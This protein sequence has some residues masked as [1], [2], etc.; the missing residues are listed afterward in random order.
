MSQN[1]LT[2]IL[3]SAIITGIS[4]GPV[5]EFLGI[6]FAQ[7]PTG[8]LCFQLP[9]ALP[10]YNVSF[11]ATAYSPA[12]PQ[13]AIEPPIVSGLLAEMLDYLMNTFYNIVTTPAKDCLT[14]NVI[15]P[16]DATPDS[17]LPVVVP[18]LKVPLVVIVSLS[19]G[20][21]QW[22]YPGALEFGVPATCK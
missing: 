16:A 7:P 13:Q 17:K 2:V 14:L 6:P 18:G 11:S 12:C 1:T 21:E 4:S 9:Q 3:D 19:N 10:P 5:N 8:N 22:V 15:T 20:F